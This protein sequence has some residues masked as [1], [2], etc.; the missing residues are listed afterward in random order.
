MTGPSW[1][2]PRAADT[3]QG[4]W[5]GDYTLCATHTWAGEGTALCVQPICDAGTDTQGTSHARHIP[6]ILSSSTQHMTCTLPALQHNTSHTQT[7]PMRRHNP[8]RI[9]PS[10][11]CGQPQSP[12]KNS[13]SELL[14][15]VSRVQHTAAEHA[16]DPRRYGHPLWR[17]RPSGRSVVTTKLPGRKRMHLAQYT[18]RGPM[19]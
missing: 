5:R 17:G 4:V 15:Y 14:L 19:Q 8:Q 6:D 2:E 11:G 18:Q 16:H 3:H 1:A 7:T 10:G 12:V 13:C 9:Q